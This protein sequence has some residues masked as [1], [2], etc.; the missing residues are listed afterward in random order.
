[1]RK[2]CGGNLALLK[3]KWRK[4]PMFRKRKRKR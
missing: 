1:M 4:Q 3:R 2:T